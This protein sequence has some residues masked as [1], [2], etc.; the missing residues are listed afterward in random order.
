M[1]E[2]QQVTQNVCQRYLK[3]DSLQTVLE[4][5]FPGQT[6]FRIRLREDQ[7]CFTAPRTVTEAEIEYVVDTDESGTLARY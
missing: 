2:A 6:D 1:A 7:W 3:K 4:R 5:L